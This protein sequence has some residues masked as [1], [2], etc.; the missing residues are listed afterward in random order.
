MILEYKKSVALVIVL[1]LLTCGIYYYFWIYDTTKNVNTYLEQEFI[2]PEIAVLLSVVTCGIYIYVWA[3]Q[4]G[5]QLTLAQRKAGMYETDNSVLYL[6]L[7]IFG[8]WII[9]VGVI[10]N[11]LNKVWDRA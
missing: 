6:I 1:S 9:A 10:Q 5:K 7:A 3:F 4:I 2:A 8:F 11:E